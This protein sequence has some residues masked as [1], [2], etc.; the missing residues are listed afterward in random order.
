MPAPAMF[1]KFKYVGSG[2]SAQQNILDN[3]PISQ[4]FE[5]G[6]QTSSAG[7][8]LIWKIHDAYRKSDGKLIFEY[9]KR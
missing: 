3:N 1:S 8:E 6:K 2:A 4:F 7:P 5:V 9:V